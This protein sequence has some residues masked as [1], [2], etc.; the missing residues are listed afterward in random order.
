M[1]QLRVG[2]KSEGLFATDEDVGR[3]KRAYPEIQNRGF[4]VN[5]SSLRKFQRI[6]IEVVPSF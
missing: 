4:C 3:V 5:P 6:L 1:L 2:R